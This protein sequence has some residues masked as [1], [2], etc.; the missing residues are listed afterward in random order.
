M[1]VAGAPLAELVA[2]GHPLL[3]ATIDLILERHRHL[4]RQ[5]AV[6]VDDGRRASRRGPRVLVMLEHAVADARPSGR[7]PHTVVSRRFE[8]VEIPTDGAPVTT[9]Y[10]PVP[11][12]PP[13]RDD[14]LA[15]SRGRSTSERGAAP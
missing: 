6:L 5:G 14:E 15:Q 1:R 13:A 12:L 8:F 3:T 4:F 2:P 7:A 10:A 11:R 9:G